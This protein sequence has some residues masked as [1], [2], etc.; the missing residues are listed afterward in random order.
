MSEKT[1]IKIS[2]LEFILSLTIVLYHIGWNDHFTASKGCQMV[3]MFIK[4]IGVVAVPV[5]SFLT[6]FLFYRNIICMKDNFIKMKKRMKSLVLPYLLWILLFYLF[7]GFVGSR[8]HLME[9]DEIG[10]VGLLKAFGTSGPMP[11]LWYVEW[12][13]LFALVSPVVYL[14]LKNRYVGLVILG[15]YTLYLVIFQEQTNARIFSSF[16]YLAGGFWGLHSTQFIK[17]FCKE[18]G[19]QRFNGTVPKMVIGI[20]ALVLFLVFWI[21]HYWIPLVQ[22]VCKIGMGISLWKILDLFSLKKC[23][24]TGYSFWIYV[25]HHPLEVV[26]RRFYTHVTLQPFLYLFLIFA[27]TLF[28]ALAS[29][30]V[31]RRFLPKVYSV[32][33]GGR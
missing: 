12:I 15:I 19:K 7:Y 6:G 25:L 32:L 16:L 5:F 2:W 9:M 14:I 21:G 13:I 18:G 30:I 8:F 22:Y 1:S 17:M 26:G 3:Y 24:I 23:S 10:L 31:L 33:S 27:T 11:H 29:G 28:V 4:E 20:G